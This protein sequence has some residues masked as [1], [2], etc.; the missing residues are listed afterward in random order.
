[1]SAQIKWSDFWPMYI[2]MPT[3]LKEQTWRCNFGINAGWKEFVQN[4]AGNIQIEVLKEAPP[5]IVVVL[6]DV[7]CS[8]AKDKLLSFMKKEKIK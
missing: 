5:E 8:G 7:L 3:E 1:M 6:Q 2:N 4:K